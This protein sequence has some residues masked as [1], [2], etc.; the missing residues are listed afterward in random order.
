[1]TFK[2]EI[3]IKASNELEAAVIAKILSKVSGHF[4]AKEWKSIATKMD[5]KLNRIKIK[6]F[7]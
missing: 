5:N 6:S 2:K 4:S 1:M 7:I 3:N